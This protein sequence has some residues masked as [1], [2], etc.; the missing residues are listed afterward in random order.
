M[1]KKANLQTIGDIDTAVNSLNNNFNALNDKL[2]NTLSRDGSTPNAM[3][4]D[5]D[6]DSNDILN[7]GKITV[8]NTLVVGGVDI[9]TQ[10]SAASGQ[11]LVEE[12][13]DNGTTD[14]RNPPV[15]ALSKDP[16]SENLVEVYLDGVAQIP[17][18]DFTLVSMP[19]AA[20]GRGIQLSADVPDN[21][22]YYFRWKVP[23]ATLSVEDADLI[24]LDDGE[25]LQDKVDIYDN[26]YARD[27]K[28]WGVVPNDRS[29]ATE[30][31]TRIQ[32]AIDWCIENGRAL[33]LGSG[34]IFTNAPIVIDGA[35][36][37]FGN[38]AGYWQKQATGT[39]F[40]ATTQFVF[41]GTGSTDYQLDGVSSMKAWGGRITNPSPQSGY[42]D[43]YYELT[44]FVVPSEDAD[45]QEF[46]QFS[47][48][49]FV[50][51]DGG[52]S[53]FEDFRILLDGGGDDGMDAYDTSGADSDPLVDANWDV[54]LYVRA[55]RGCKFRNVQAVG[56]W[57]K[58]LGLLA[59][60]HFGTFPA[61]LY[62]TKFDD[63]VFS[64][65]AI[66][67]P[68]HAPITATTSNTVEIPWADDH[69]FTAGG[70]TDL[71]LSENSRAGSPFTFTSVTRVTDGVDTGVDSLRFNGV[72]PDPTG[73]TGVLP[74]YRGGGSSGLS[75]HTTRITGW[76]HPANRPSNKSDLTGSGVF[77][78]P[79]NTIEISGNEL[80]EIDF[81]RASIEGY[82][83]VGV[84]LGDCRHVHLPTYIE[85]NGPQNYRFIAWPARGNNPNVAGG[86]PAV[87]ET[88]KPKF[89]PEGSTT[90]GGFIDMRPYITIG[91]PPS[92]YSGDSGLFD[93]D[94]LIS[95]RFGESEGSTFFGEER[96]QEIRSIET[97]SGANGEYIKYSNG[98]AELW[99]DGFELDRV[100]NAYC[101]NFWT[102]PLE[103]ADNNYSAQFTVDQDGTTMTPAYSELGVGIIRTTTTTGLRA[104]QYSISG[105]T[106]FAANDV[107]NVRIRVIGRW[108]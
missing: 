91:E 32:Q 86:G 76:A 26:F 107:V 105:L 33:S 12:G 5:L 18:V 80:T 51:R 95:S 11:G 31:G 23:S 84:Y 13:F 15:Y 47:A 29:A 87:T 69:P 57:R 53:I 1:T 50:N 17:G 72:S 61:T 58:R 48:A 14:G 79:G 2:D 104:R 60:P 78:T 98:V 19:M 36:K 94:G 82:E 93:P 81:T 44:S 20:S 64:M 46:E 88:L 106:G 54:G 101:E 77:D 43:A 102:F 27:I 35:I 52:K 21:L 45:G 103:L 85:G 9:F 7:A 96:Y 71:R 39:N 97:G 68:D 10:V 8:Q 28:D 59:V 34:S 83:Q 25:T 22:R 90:L 92:E 62:D 100:N 75:F 70:N 65:V 99:I 49:F 30:N 41:T 74:P 67:G 16:K 3:E 24:V 38:G 73:K 63:C 66:R 6:M 42:N 55:A 56:Q 40:A 37:M 4:A 108:Q 89:E